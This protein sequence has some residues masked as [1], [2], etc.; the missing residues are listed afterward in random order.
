[1][2]PILSFLTFLFF[3]IPSHAE[4]G[5]ASVYTSAEGKWTASGERMSNRAMTAAHRKLPLGSMVVVHH[6]QH[7]VKLRINDRGPF[8]KGR[9]LD[10]TPAAAARLGIDGLGVVSVTAVK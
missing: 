9:I 4:T 1:V 5:I 7:S 10:L 8:V 3:T 2:I 6:G